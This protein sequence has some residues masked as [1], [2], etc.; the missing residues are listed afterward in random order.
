MALDH[1]VLL[2]VLVFDVFDFLVLVHLFVLLDHLLLEL[3][4][5]FF[6]E[7]LALVLELLFELLGLPLLLDH[8]FELGLLC[9]R[10]LFEHPLLF[11]LLLE[12]GS[13]QF[14]APLG[15]DFGLHSFL[16]PGG[17]LIGF[18]RSLGSQS[19]QLG[20]SIGGLFLQLSQSL[21][22]LFFFVFDP[23]LLSD[24]LGLFVG[25]LFDVRG[26]LLLLI[27]LFLLPLLDD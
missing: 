22:F 5:V 20:L 19:I 24:D 23:F 3:Q 14:L 25:F 13:G 27:L 17:T 1:E 11:F 21:D 2:L 7:L 4:G 8:G 15:P 9:S 16:F 10:L 12:P 26:D 18:R 6:Q